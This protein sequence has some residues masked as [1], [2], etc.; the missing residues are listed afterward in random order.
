[1]SGEPRRARKQAYAA[2][3]IERSDNH[4]LIVT[5]EEPDVLTRQWQFPRGL[6]NRGESPEAAMRR[7]AK[8][9]LGIRIEIVVGQ[10]PIMA[11]VDATAAE[12]RYFFCGL[13][14]GV[15]RP[16]SYAE[17]QWIPRAHF[18]EYDFD[19]ASQCVADWIADS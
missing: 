4:V 17:I 15:A 13:V 2:G 6:I 7:I 19:P 8:A 12:L 14:D 11:E 5:F 16:G 1:M 10:P 18:V 3:I 9:R